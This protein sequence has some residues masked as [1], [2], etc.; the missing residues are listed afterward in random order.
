MVEPEAAQIQPKGQPNVAPKFAWQISMGH[1]G[2]WQPVALLDFPGV[3][4]C[5]SAEQQDADGAPVSSQP[6]FFGQPGASEAEQ[7]QPR[8]RGEGI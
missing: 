7:A 8:Q 3:P 1:C 2:A 4:F 6:I 5:C